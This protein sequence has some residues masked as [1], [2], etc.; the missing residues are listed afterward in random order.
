MAARSQ[1]ETVGALNDLALSTLSAMDA[2]QQSGMASG[3]EQFLKRMEQMAGQQQGINSMT[4]QLAM[5]QMA[6]SSKEGMM[7]RL[8]QEQGQLKKSLQQMIQE[9]RGSQNAGGNLGGIVQDMEE[10]IKDFN[11]GRVTRKTIDRQQRI[12]SRMLDSQKSMR[13]RDLSEKRRSF[14]GEDIFRTG[15]EGLPE[16]MGQRRNLAMEALNLALKAGYP[17]DYQDMIRRYFNALAQ[18]PQMAP[19]DE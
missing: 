7:K 1:K 6:A 11:R 9:M 16:D 13:Q 2:M 18:S 5:G 19:E 10:V 15:P 8:G 12:L 17:R 4:F 3:F 14:A